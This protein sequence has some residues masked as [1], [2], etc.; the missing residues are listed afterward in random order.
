MTLETERIA[1]EGRCQTLWLNDDSPPT[2]LTPI[3]FSSHKFE[4]TEAGNS[5]RLTIRNGVATAESIGSPGTNLV[6]NIGVIMI[7]I[8]VPG[9]GGEATVRPLAETAMG[10]FRNV[11][12]GGITC[13]VPY[14]SSQMEDAPFLIWTVVA[15]FKRDELNG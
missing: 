9:G 13:W 6:R 11:T 10:I 15:P 12:F 7:Q 2:A 5:A 8:F 4:P 3:G 14:V 1:I